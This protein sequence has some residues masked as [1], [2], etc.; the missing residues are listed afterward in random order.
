VPYQPV[1][2]RAAAPKPMSSTRRVPR[3]PEVDAWLRRVEPTRR[4]A[5]EKLRRAIHRLVPEAE[6]C[7]SYKIPAF[8]LRESVIAGFSAT[9]KGCSY[10]PFSG[11]TLGSLA[12]V[13]GGYSQTLS[14]LH[15]TPARPLP[16]DLLRQLLRARMAELG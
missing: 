2:P 16:E 5:L 4:A 9:A 14:A 10:Y 13:L 8:R 3:S 11:R 1:L 12:Q 15:F 6:E 7:I